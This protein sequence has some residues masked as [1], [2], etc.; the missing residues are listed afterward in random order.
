MWRLETWLKKPSM[1]SS[2]SLPLHHHCITSTWK[3]RTEAEFLFEKITL[4]YFKTSLIYKLTTKSPG[5][6]N[7][8]KL[9][10]VVVPTRPPPFV[11]KYASKYHIIPIILLINIKH[12][13]G[14]HNTTFWTISLL[15]FSIWNCGINILPSPFSWCTNFSTSN[16]CFS[17]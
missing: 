11:K 16:T 10:L 15:Q 13:M 7:S 9:L 3:S 8:W 2:K 4:S 14:P 12:T 5:G 6:L 1:K 17:S